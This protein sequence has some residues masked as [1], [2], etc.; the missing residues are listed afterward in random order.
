[1]EMWWHKNLFRNCYRPFFSLV[2]MHVQ[3]RREDRWGWKHVLLNVRRL[4]RHTLPHT[5]LPSLDSSLISSGYVILISELEALRE[6]SLVVGKSLATCGESFKMLSHFKLLISC[7]KRICVLRRQP[8]CEEL[9]DEGLDSFFLFSHR[10]FFLR[11]AVKRSVRARRRK[12]AGKI[13]CQKTG[14]VKISMQY[15]GCLLSLTGEWGR[16]IT[17]ARFKHGNIYIYSSLIYIYNL[18]VLFFSSLWFL[19]IEHL[20]HWDSNSGH[21]FWPNSLNAWSTSDYTELWESGSR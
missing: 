12:P 14:N 2:S 17:Q 20:L 6:R 5:S 18:F 3:Y 7:S 1:M 9:E 16:V 21:F 8:L 11:W 19:V 4:S 10:N 13:S 15:F